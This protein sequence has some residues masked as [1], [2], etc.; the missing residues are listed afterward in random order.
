MPKVCAWC[1]T[2][3]NKE[4]HI[5]LFKC[6]CKTVRYCSKA[7]QKQDRSQ[8]KL[9]CQVNVDDLLEATADDLEGLNSK[10]LKAR[11]LLAEIVEDLVQTGKKYA[12]K[13]CTKLAEDLKKKVASGNFE[14]SDLRLA[15]TS[16]KEQLKLQHKQMEKK[17]KKK[18]K[19]KKTQKKEATE[20]ST[21]IPVSIFEMNE[22]AVVHGLESAAGKLL[23]DK[24]VIII[25][26]LNKNG[27][28]GCILV[29]DDANQKKKIK[30]M[31]LVK[32]TK[33]SQVHNWCMTSQCI[34]SDPSKRP[35]AVWC[36]IHNATESKTDV[37]FYTM[38]GAPRSYWSIDADERDRM[39]Q[40]MKEDPNFMQTAQNIMGLTATAAAQAESNY[41]KETKTTATKTTSS[42][43][44]SKT[45]EAIEPCPICQ[46]ELLHFNSADKNEHVNSCLDNPGNE[47]IKAELISYLHN[48]DTDNHV[49][50]NESDNPDYSTWLQ[51]TLEPS[52][53]ANAPTVLA[54]EVCTMNIDCIHCS[55][56]LEHIR[57]V[58]CHNEERKRMT[59]CEIC[60]AW[61]CSGKQLSVIIVKV[62][63][64]SP[65]LFYCLLFNHSFPTNPNSIT[66]LL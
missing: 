16:L 37:A 21:S 24:W 66:N 7:C 4:S 52:S 47:E 48:P 17:K 56:C 12:N 28:Y 2:K 61:C 27:R 46:C 39:F 25:K 22:I 60:S 50:N 13:E 18:Q 58:A 3:K 19:K 34:L 65:F 64:T 42:K 62:T 32:I 14:P 54:C 20:T 8:H 45:S 5:K 11:N 53:V 49:G 43:A 26:T 41:I 23:N 63:F 57:C 51:R 44:K 38:L 6:V 9:H 33:P 55:R 1:G 29:D 10:E 40:Q 35:D 36:L 30:A 59:C 15:I 31:N